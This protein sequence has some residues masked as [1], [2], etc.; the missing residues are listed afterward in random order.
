MAIRTEPVYVRRRR[1]ALAGLVGV[2]G[3]SALGVSRLTAD[4]ATAAPPARSTAP[5]VVG[6]VASAPPRS[7][8]VPTGKPG[9]SARSALV[10]VQRLT[11]GLNP[12]SVV[13]SGTGLVYAQNMMYQHT[14]SVFGADGALR[15]RI[16]DAVDL[17]GFGVAGHPGTSKGSPVEAAFSPDGATAWVSNYAMYG[18][19]F[20]PEGRDACT[21]PQAS[22]P[23]Y[24]YRID[25]R[26]STIA[27]VVQ[28]GH[29]PKYVATTP[30]G[31]MVLV[32]NWCS[33]DL[34]VIDAK[35][36][37]VVR[38]VPL[39]G[40]HPRGIAVAPDSG[41]AYVTIMGSDL[42]VAVDL[43]TGKVRPFTHT[44]KGARHI[45]MSPD[46]TRL[47]VTNNAAGSVSEVERSTGTVKRTVKVG[48]EPRSMAMS[49]DGGALYV[50]NYQ[51]STV[52]KIRTS[53]FSVVQTVRTDGLPIGITYEPTTKSVWVACY[54]G[55]IL[56]FDDSRLP[57]T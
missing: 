48:I 54:S 12:K 37:K 17:A 16:K 18:S 29:V 41:T 24:V 56:V 20:K 40:R 9:P 44:G 38:T 49:P 30:D 7:A 46:G 35:T 10:R 1:V 25:T 2:V 3:L 45:V 43:K 22:S 19:G 4:D 33:M 13:A 14:V 53:D 36:S 55:S 23:S 52:S 28:V 26:T 5:A 32:T 34:S 11:G 21:G 39:P 15:A 50:V 8:S 27:G 51:S 57:A 31:A 47:Y 6:T 42:V